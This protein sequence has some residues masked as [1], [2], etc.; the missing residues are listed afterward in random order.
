MFTRFCE[1]LPPVIPLNIVSETRAVT[2]VI[3]ISGIVK[4]LCDQCVLNS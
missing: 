2:P 1:G 4:M 3:C